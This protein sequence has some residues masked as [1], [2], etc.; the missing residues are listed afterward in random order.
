MVLVETGW[1]GVDWIYLTHD[2]FKW[3]ALVNVVMNLQVAK[4]AG[5]LWSGC[6][7]DGLSS[8]AQLHR[9]SKLY[10]EQLI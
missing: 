3:R 2:R 1:N 7:N 10:S 8:R 5:K 9:V 4:N 6:T